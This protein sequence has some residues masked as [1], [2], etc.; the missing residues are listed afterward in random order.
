VCIRFGGD[1]EIDMLVK[2]LR[3][4][5]DIFDRHGFIEK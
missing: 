3:K 5:A 4:A 2:I 1:A